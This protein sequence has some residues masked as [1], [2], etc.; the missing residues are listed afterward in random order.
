MLNLLKNQSNTCYT[1]AALW[2]GTA[3]YT[4]KMVSNLDREINPFFVLTLQDFGDRKRYNITPTSMAG[5][6][7]Y[8]IEDSL[9]NVYEIGLAEITE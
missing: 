2:G 9:G 8:T 1:F 7:D 3:P 5:T 6:Y 4:L